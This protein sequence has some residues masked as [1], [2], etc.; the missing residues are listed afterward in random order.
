MHCKICDKNIEK[1]TKYLIVDNHW[2]CF[3]CWDTMDDNE[4]R[5]KCKMQM[6]K[7]TPRTNM[8]EC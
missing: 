3:E 1:E 8:L 2:S 4:L 7:R 5:E 6:R